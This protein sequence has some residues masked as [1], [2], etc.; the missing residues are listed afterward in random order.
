MLIAVIICIVGAMLS[1]IIAGLLGL[2]GG[3]VLVPLFF[4]LFPLFDYT[5]HL[6]NIAIGTSLMCII[7]TSVSSIYSHH[8]KKGI[9]FPVLPSWGGL[10]FIGAVVGAFI[11]VGISETAVRIVYVVATLILVVYRLFQPNKALFPYKALFSWALPMPF[12]SGWLSATIG[13]GGGNNVQMLAVFGVPIKNAVA[14]ASVMGLLIAVPATVV[15]IIEGWQYR[16][17]LPPYSLGYVNI[18]MVAVIVPIS[19][20][21]ANIAARVTYMFKPLHLNTLSC[22]VGILLS[23]RMAYGLF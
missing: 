8:K 20:V 5:D 14:T 1:G 21:T 22:V 6:K 11:A 9:H 2:G 17:T 12:L 23:L 3:A 15:Y 13:L 18:L 10:H 19:M 4:F 16:D 7:F